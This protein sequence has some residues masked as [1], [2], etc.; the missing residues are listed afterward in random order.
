M[1]K[2]YVG[3]NQYRGDNRNFSQEYTDKQLE[4]HRNAIPLDHAN[5]SV[6]L[7]KLAGDVKT[8]INS[9]ADKETG[10]GGF[11]GGHNAMVLGGGA[12]VG[13][14][15]S[16]SDGFAGGKGAVTAVDQYEQT[17]SIDAIQL[18]TGWNQ[19]EKTLQIYDHQ[20]LDAQGH[21]PAARMPQLEN[22]VDKEDGKGL[23]SNDYTTA[24]KTKLAGIEAGANN[25]VHPST[26]PASMITQDSTHRF[27]TDTEK[28]DWNSKLGAE[29]ILAGDNVTV[30]SSDGNVTISAAGGGSGSGVTVVD[31]LT[32]TST[33]NALSANQGKVLNDT[34]A[35]KATEQGGFAGGN[36]ASVYDAGYP[37]TGTGGAIGKNA[38][39]PGGG[40]AIGEDTYTET[41]G[42]IGNGAS[43]MTGGAVGEG[44][45]DQG[46]GFAGGKSAVTTNAGGAA[47]R[48]ANA[49]DGG[50]VG[51]GAITGNGFAGGRYAKTVNTSGTGIDAIQLGTGTNT[52]AKTLQVYDYQLMDA[53]GNIPAERL[54]NAGGSS[55]NITKNPDA[56]DGDIID[57]HLTVGNRRVSDTTGIFTGTIGT[58]SFTSGNENMASGDYSVA[59][60]NCNTASGTVS[61]AVGDENTAS[62]SSSAAL[63][64]EGNVAS[65]Y[66][67]AVIAGAYNNSYGT[68]SAVL[69]GETNT[70]ATGSMFTAVVG[71]C[72][73]QAAGSSS[74]TIGGYGN[75][76]L[77]N[78]VKLGH[79]SSAG[80][81]GNDSG[82]TGDAFIIGN[83][84]GTT[85]ANA[86]RVTY[87][88]K[89]YGLS[90]F[91]SSGADYAE[92]F[93]WADG[94]PNGE[95]RRGLFVTLAGEKIRLA[96]A[97][98][99][100]ILGAVSANYCFV[101]DVQSDMWQGMY[102]T[103]VFGEKMME[104]VA[105]PETTD[106]TTG[107]TIPAHEYETFQ[108]N[109]DYD[110]AQDYISR[111]NRPEW[112]PVGL[113]GKIVMVDD[114]TCEVNGFCTAGEGGKATKAQTETTCRVMAR[115]DETHVKVLLK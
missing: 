27:V 68:E 14:G 93:E 87:A 85:R 78:Q 19:E 57:T 66:D 106:E 52:T 59:V 6:S 50:A 33:T 80:T 31:S 95:D 108:L 1:G 70:T 110:P 84:T 16:T 115:I 13:N 36:G 60:G 35:D 94:N 48:N 65:G 88:G 109:P 61:L 102:L 34:K 8:F 77:S 46:G 37:E 91:A 40:G 73:N 4:K 105:V 74:V 90:T 5:G 43:S 17:Y 7:A 67:A 92:Y 111:E 42:A 96:T 10:S 76:A 69:G 104:T 24:E 58:Q 38:S 99:T 23:S 22:K 2:L 3:K 25:Y 55:A 45:Q 53:D 18:G 71:G 12:A 83:G 113:V 56:T 64:G 101:G 114:G 26:H 82:T 51:D 44:A 103:D 62:G 89:A 98:D 75:N 47:G 21:I 86:F 9:K 28:A 97:E 100:Y 41:G 32:S 39:T 15:A 30:T 63:G 29:N 107:R 112:S 54:T 81:A 20:L 11:A 49:E 79:Y 72:G